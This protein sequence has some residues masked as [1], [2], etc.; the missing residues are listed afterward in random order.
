VF[1][2]GHIRHIRQTHSSR[3]FELEPIK[4]WFLAGSWYLDHMSTVTTA[5]GSAWWR[6][7]NTH[8]IHVWLVWLVTFPVELH[9][10]WSLIVCLRSPRRLQPSV[11]SAVHHGSA[12][13]CAGTGLTG[14][15]GLGLSLGVQFQLY[16]SGYFMLFHHSYDSYGG[17]IAH[18]ITG[19][20][21]LIAT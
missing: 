16:I 18:G 10:D 11:P 5:R 8:L 7:K 17:P 12:A 3:S 21:P 6:V 15:S 14:G 4:S 19:W 20:L 1:R 9:V 13:W 2:R